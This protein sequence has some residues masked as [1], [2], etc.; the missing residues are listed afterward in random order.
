M[1]AKPRRAI[2]SLPGNVQAMKIIPQNVPTLG[3][4]WAEITSL[5]HQ[6]Y[7]REHWGEFGIWAAF[8]LVVGPVVRWLPRP[9][10]WGKCQV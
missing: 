10:I 6:P 4:V 1:T 9:N 7:C 5:A 3:K 2:R 8:L